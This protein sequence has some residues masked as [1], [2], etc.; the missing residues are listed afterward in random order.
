LSSTL[1]DKG[2][3]RGM[4]QQV[5]SNNMVSTN[6]NVLSSD[7]TSTRMGTREDVTFIVAMY[8]IVMG[9]YICV[10]LFVK[11]GLFAFIIFC[12]TTSALLGRLTDWY[13]KFEILSG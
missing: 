11:D 6:R 10:L 5:G 9:Y 8:W 4:G 2:A 1:S 12:Q 3:E 13:P 7:E